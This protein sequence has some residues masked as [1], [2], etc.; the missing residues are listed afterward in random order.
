MFRKRLNLNLLAWCHLL[1]DVRALRSSDLGSVIYKPL[2]PVPI[3][4]CVPA[5][6]A[7]CLPSSNRPMISLIFEHLYRFHGYLLLLSITLSMFSK[8]IIDIPRRKKCCHKHLPYGN[9][10]ATSGILP[11]T[12]RFFGTSLF[13]ARSPD[14]AT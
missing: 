4:A 1:P 11:I 13:W 8:L 10:L 9:H 2:P 6:I 12:K 5:P 7:D 3:F 14:H